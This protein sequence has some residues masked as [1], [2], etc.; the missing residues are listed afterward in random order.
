MRLRTVLIAAALAGGFFWLTSVADWKLR[1]LFNPIERTGRLW[2]APD[3]AHSASYSADEQNNIDIYRMAS[4]A[5]V[6]ITSVISASRR[7]RATGWITTKAFP[8]RKRGGISAG[9]STARWTVSWPAHARIK[10]SS[11]MDSR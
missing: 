10:S 1:D 11:H 9:G 5:T 6:N 3:V 8:A 2:T 7:N 4:E